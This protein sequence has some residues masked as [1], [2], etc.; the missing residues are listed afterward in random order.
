MPRVAIL[1]L[2]GAIASLA[3]CKQMP[4]VATP[5]KEIQGPSPVANS[6][7]SSELLTCFSMKGKSD[8]FR[9]AVNDLIDGTG[10]TE[11]D[12]TNSRAITQ[13]PDLMMVS[14]LAQA[15]VTILN[16]NSVGIAEWEMKGA[17]ERK[18]GEG[19]SVKNENEEVQFRPVKVGSFVGSTHYVTGAITELNWNIGSSAAEVGAYS[20]SAGARVYRI[21]IALD[22]MVT[23]TITTEIVHA[24]SYKKQLVGY[25]TSVGA[26]RFMY[27]PVLSSAM[28]PGMT[29][30]LELFNANL[31]NKKNEPVQT[32]VRWLIELSAYDI[33]RSLTNSGGECDNLLPPDTLSIK[34]ARTSIVKHAAA[35]AQQTLDARAPSPPPNTVNNN[36]R[37]AAAPKGDTSEAPR[38][39]RP[40]Q[41]KRSAD[42]V[43]LSEGD[44]FL[45]FKVV[46]DAVQTTNT[47]AELAKT[48]SIPIEPEQR[49][50]GSFP[51]PGSK[52]VRIGMKNVDKTKAGIVCF[53]M[54]VAGDYCEVLS[55]QQLAT[56]SANVVKTSSQ[57]AP[58][59]D[60]EIVRIP[61]NSEAGDYMIVLANAENGTAASAKLA[62]VRGRYGSELQNTPL[63]ISRD[64]SGQTQF[65]IVGSG[66]S[67][68]TANTICFRVKVAGGECEARPI[69]RTEVQR[70]IKRGQRG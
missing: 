55:A 3:A 48:A 34:P 49:R 13:R 11:G 59:P 35:Q 30:A 54:Q 27:A 36:Q 42:Q 39:A 4:S 15:G 1:V 25:E 45:V 64:P 31:G 22:I 58:A 23:N 17:I 53:R 68:R 12:S 52:K 19:R 21:S 56:E 67:E 57:I 47:I 9:L 63:R 60:Q 8:P 70:V 29:K 33:V 50:L 2:I 66:I 62:E 6:T 28:A 16:R 65:L 69:G 46:D 26:F 51:I 38:D 20:V 32:A 24:R 10:V 37:Q 14:A 5:V 7:P 43:T 40:P 61:V 44:A 18:L 41:S